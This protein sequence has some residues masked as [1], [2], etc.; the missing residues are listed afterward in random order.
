ML[1][2]SAASTTA[3]I[4]LTGCPRLE[5]A[6][7]DKSAAK[8]VL[9]VHAAAD[10][11]SSADSHLP[12]VA[13]KMSAPAN[14][15]AYVAADSQSTRHRQEQDLVTYQAE[16]P[17]NTAIQSA[18]ELSGH[19]ASKPRPISSLQ[20]GGVCRHD[21]SGAARLMQASMLTGML[22]LSGATEASVTTAPPVTSASTPQH[23]PKRHKKIFM[24]GN[25]KAYYGYRLGTELTE[26]P[27]VQ[28]KGLSPIVCQP[29]PSIRK[30]LA[31]T[32]LMHAVKCLDQQCLL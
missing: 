11:V 26:D 22:T 4:P 32:V 25:Y 10:S 7:I 12:A 5:T 21:M 29:C 6:L 19:P 31:A 27:R 8:P 14:S 13:G 16:M 9:L 24:H 2:G 18:T 3:C 15:S 20:P 28:V 23:E 30:P 17:N 1:A